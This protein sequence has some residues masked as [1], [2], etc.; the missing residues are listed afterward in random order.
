MTRVLVVD[1]EEPARERLCQLLAALPD[2]EI[3]GQAANGEQA[4]EAIGA[5]RPDVVLL[6]IQMPGL[7]GLE[8][9]ACLH[10]PRPRIIFCTAF[11]QYAVDAFEVNAVDYLLKPVNRV[12]LVQAIERACARPEAEAEA[13][14]D[15]VTEAAQG[16]CTRLLARCGDRFRIVHQKEV[17][18]L[19][20]EGGLTRLHT[21]DRRYVLDPTLN[22]LEE[23][24]DPALFFRISRAAIVNL[25]AVV[26]VLPLVGGVA[27][28]ALN[29]GA[30][31]EVSRRR[32]RELLE[33]LESG[34]PKR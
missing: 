10:R 2:V 29:T 11:D 15:R 7:N 34:D 30:V 16:K 28:V 25:D 22:E 31:L 32:V 17:V 33:R 14:V 19:S 13:D 5:L 21:R 20:S 6:D 23:R 8:V 4:M 26:E 18:Y 9:A 24:L 27:S 1:D 3:A 12:R